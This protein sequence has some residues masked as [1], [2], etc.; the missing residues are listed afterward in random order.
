MASGVDGIVS[1]FA[2]GD[3]ETFHTM[4]MCEGCLRNMLLN[5]TVAYYILPLGLAF[6][7]RIVD[8]D[9]GASVD[10]LLRSPSSGLVR[11]NTYK[12]QSLWPEINISP[13]Y[14]QIAFFWKVFVI[15]A[16]TA[17]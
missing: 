3:G 16:M 9:K 12:L 14:I 15:S 13:M 5:V 1:G 6:S 17:R 11:L 2:G 8:Q 7:S 10:D 4:F